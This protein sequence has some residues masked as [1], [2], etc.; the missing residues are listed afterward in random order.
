MSKPRVKR[1]GDSSPSV[2]KRSHGK[3]GREGILIGV[4]ARTHTHTQGI[5]IKQT[6]EL[7]NILVGFGNLYRHKMGIQLGTL[8][9]SN[10]RIR[11]F[12]HMPGPAICGLT[13]NLPQ[14]DVRRLLREKSIQRKTKQGLG[15]LTQ[16]QHLSY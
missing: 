16:G 10:V 14:K 11:L 7:P 2:G 9:H 4:H 8:A 12:L 5:I 3:S 6:K 13:R 1:T 15:R